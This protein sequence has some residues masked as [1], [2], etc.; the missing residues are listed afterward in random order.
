VN[1][2]QP[3]TSEFATILRNSLLRN[4]SHK[5][6]CPACKHVTTFTSKRYIPSRDLPS[7]L[8]ANANVYNDETWDF[9]Q[10][11]RNKTFLQPQ[12]SFHG[13]IDGV[14]DPEIA[15]YII[16]VCSQL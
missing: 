7:V 11:G 4:I 2:E 8:V 16:R 15:S 5:A 13:Q 9:W 12:V 10:D 3:A 14:D 6:T 1:N